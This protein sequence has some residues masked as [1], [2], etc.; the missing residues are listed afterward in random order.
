MWAF[1]TA[2]LSVIFFY[3][4]IFRGRAFD[5]ASWTMV[6]A[7]IAWTL[8]AFF[9]VA[10]QCGSHISNLWSSAANVERHCSSGAAVGI[11]FSIPDVITDGLILAM[12]LYWVSG[13]F[14]NRR[15][16]C[17]SSPDLEA[18][19][20]LLEESGCLRNLSFRCNVS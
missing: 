20:V 2:K 5:I 10:F 12:P 4:S 3:R 11:G 14:P 9:A 6:G 16:I 7:V 17:S 8:G 19:D 15:S 13:L 18:K 1:G